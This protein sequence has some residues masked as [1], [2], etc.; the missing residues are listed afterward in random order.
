MCCEI[1]ICSK[2]LSQVFVHMHVKAECAVGGM[3]PAAGANSLSMLLCFF[4]ARGRSL[5]D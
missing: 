3:S 5:F 4:L 2:L 1:L